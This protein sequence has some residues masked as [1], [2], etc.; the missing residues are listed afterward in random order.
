MRL[1]YKIQ[2]YKICIYINKIYIISDPIIVI[3]CGG[4]VYV[5]YLLLYTYSIHI[6]IYIYMKVYTTLENLFFFILFS[7][8]FIRFFSCGFTECSFYTIY[9]AEITIYKTFCDLDFV[10]FF[11]NGKFFFVYMMI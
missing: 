3:M 1:L 9:N 11:V 5:Y 7:L 2:Q 4:S 8:F 6:F 10:D